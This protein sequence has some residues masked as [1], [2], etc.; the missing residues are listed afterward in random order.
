M[1]FTCSKSTIESLEHGVKYVPRLTIK[2][3]EQRHLHCSSV[4]IVN[5]EHISNLFLVFLLLILNK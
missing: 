5:F 1:T 3:P 2:T 4:F